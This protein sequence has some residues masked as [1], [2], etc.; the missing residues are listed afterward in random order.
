M[1]MNLV[2]LSSAEIDALPFGYVALSKD[3]TIL[4]YNRYEANLARI[5]QGQQ[6]GKNFFRD[7]APCTQVQEFEGRFRDFAEGRTTS[8]TL[9]FDFLFNFRHGL[10]SA[11]IGLVRSPGSDEIILTVNRVL[12]DQASL[13][14]DL[15][16]TSP[17]GVLKN[18][19][20]KRVLMTSE[21]LWRGL[22]AVLAAQGASSPGGAGAAMVQLG[23]QWGLAHALKVD[24]LLQQE[25]ATTLRDSALENVLEMLSRSLAALGLGLFK[26]DFSQR[27][28]GLIVIEHSL[29]PFVEFFPERE[30]GSCALL[31]GIHA[32]LLSYMSGRRLTGKEVYCSQRPSEPCV[33][34]VATEERLAKLLAAAGGTPDF[35]VLTDLKQAAKA[36]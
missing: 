28:R 4:K 11:R 1:E 13:T 2:G 33:F 18:S 24:N 15:D 19:M 35:A 6:I 10:Q 20:G 22:D 16:S 8:Q 7:V 29:S 9:S 31:A 32:G 17:G 25:Q 26:V 27:D 30:G 34:V 23:I 3:G 12:D 5:D 14:S 36:K 21:D